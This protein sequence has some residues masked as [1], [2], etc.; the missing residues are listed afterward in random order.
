MI[1]DQRQTWRQ[2]YHA[3]ALQFLTWLPFPATTSQVLAHYTTRNT[4][5]ELL[6]D[7]MALPE[8]TFAAPDEFASALVAVHRQ[9]PP[10]TW[11]SREMVDQ[12]R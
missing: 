1:A 4:P 9:R 10:H 5:M 12:A 3:R 2:A 7:T 8:R 6:E 11:V